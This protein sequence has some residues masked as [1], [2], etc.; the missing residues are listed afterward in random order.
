[1]QKPSR[2]SQIYQ[3]RSISAWTID[4]NIPS[5]KTTTSP[6][7]TA[8]QPSTAITIVREKPAERASKAGR[9]KPLSKLSLARAGSPARRH[10]SNYSI[11]APGSSPND[12][13]SSPVFTIHSRRASVPSITTRSPIR[14]DFPHNALRAKSRE[15]R[16]SMDARRKSGSKM[17][18]PADT[19]GV[20]AR[21]LSVDMSNVLVR[22]R[23]PTEAEV[24]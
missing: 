15:A 12:S 3:P 6:Q 16:S 1:L 7:Q 18:N 5:R 21:S 11:S 20:L 8:V 4:Q 10:S 17:R 22:C 9:V 19:L 24:H 2:K 14:K 23:R 13:A